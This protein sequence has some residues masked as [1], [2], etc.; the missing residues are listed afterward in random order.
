MC[1]DLDSPICQRW[2]ELGGMEVLGETVAGPTLT[3]D[4]RA[5]IQ[6]FKNGVLFLTPS[7]VYRIANTIFDKWQALLSKQTVDGKNLQAAVGYPTQDD[8]TFAVEIQPGGVPN[9]GLA[10]SASFEGGLIVTFDLLETTRVVVYGEIFKTYESAGLQNGGL[11]LPLADEEP[12]GAGVRMRFQHGDI[13]F[14]PFQKTGAFIIMGPIRGRWNKLGGVDSP[15]GFPTS[16]QIPIN[17]EGE[18]VGQVQ[19]FHDGFIFWSAQTGAWEVLPPILHTYI[20]SRAN[21]PLGPLGFPISGQQSSPT[22]LTIFNN[23][24][25]G[26]IAWRL[27]GSLQPAI[28]RIVFDLEFFVTRFKASGGDGLA[29]DIEFFVNGSVGATPGGN[30]FNGRIPSGDGFLLAEAEV[31]RKFPVP[32]LMQGERIV[33]FDFEGEEDDDGPFNENDKL[34]RVHVDYDIDSYWGLTESNST[35]PKEPESS[36]KVICGMKEPSR[37]LDPGIPWRQQAFWQFSSPNFPDRKLTTKHYADTFRDIDDGTNITPDPITWINEGWESIFY[38]SVYKSLAETGH[39]F[40]MCA[41]AARALANSV[42]WAEPIFQFALDAQGLIDEIKIAHGYQVSAEVIDWVLGQGFPMMQTHHP[43]AVYDETRERYDRGDYA[44]LCVTDGFFGGRNHVVFPYEWKPADEN[45]RRLILVANPN[46][47]PASGFPPPA[48][49]MDFGSFIE[50]DDD[51]Q[52]R[53][54]RTG[55]AYTGG[56][57]FGGRLYYVPLSMFNSPPRTPGYEALGLLLSGYWIILGDAGETAQISN[58]KGETFYDPNLTGAP[59]RWDQIR[60]SGNI[61][62]LTRIPVFDCENGPEFYL[63]RGDPGDLVHQIH[64]K[65]GTSS[66]TDYHWATHS[67]DLSV[68]LKATSPGKT[69]DIIRIR[70]RRT[71]DPTVH[72]ELANAGAPR[73]VELSISSG[74]VAQRFKRFRVTEMNFTQARQLSF[75]L[76][77]RGEG[78]LIENAADTNLS[79]KVSAGKGAAQVLKIPP[80]KL[81]R[82]DPDWQQANPTFKAETFTHGYRSFLETRGLSG[83]NGMRTQFPEA[84]SL[85]NL[86]RL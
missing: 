30:F 72:V 4:D 12:F 52:F 66:G 82:V 69:A 55:G 71:F 79:C 85:R 24:E 62:G 46:F 70:N 61:P 36:F 3:T 39:C 25:K 6:Q 78:L 2:A 51:N 84:S 7:G 77:N 49:E 16:N 10:R 40:G 80:A 37:P 54:A 64:A 57:T 31:N 11:G 45:G 50:I 44:V 23:F 43:K 83:K 14:D 81:V 75:R 28:P 59:T 15:L 47:P 74:R 34:G 13:C 21:G 42:F 26:V 76:L 29:G 17:R 41:L 68:A 8:F 5:T 56:E 63:G 27:D 86:L 19:H 58:D 73:N 9:V 1:D 22:G 53:L 35:F 32:G 18:V 38:H 33:S 60:R 20:G 67:P 65:S 48:S